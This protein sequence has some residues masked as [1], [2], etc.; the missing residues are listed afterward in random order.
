MFSY[1]LSEKLEKKI[2]KVAKKDKILALIFRKKIQEVISH[3][4]KT[5]DTY[6]NLKS[7]QNNYKRIHLTGSYVLLFFVDKPNKHVIFV[8]IVHWDFAYS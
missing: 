5:I 3:S 2:R 8:D 7:P 4:T 1:N 6:K